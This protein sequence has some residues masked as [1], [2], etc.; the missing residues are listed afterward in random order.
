MRFILLLLL[1]SFFFATS[2]IAKEY[3][4]K[5]S[6]S[7]KKK[8]R[9]SIIISNNHFKKPRVDQSS[10]QN[11]ATLNRYLNQLDPYSKHFS[12]KEVAFKQKRGKT[13]RLGIGLDLLID[14]D[15]ILGVPIKEG[16][17]YQAGIT[18]PVYICSINKKKIKPSEFESYQF[19][20]EFSQ[21]QIVEIQTMSKTAKKLGKYQLKVQ[22]FPQKYVDIKLAG[23]INVLSI[24]QF[25]NDSTLKI[26]NALKSFADNKSLIIDLRFNPGGDLYAT[27]DTLSFFIKQNLTVAYLKENNIKNAIPLKTVSGRSISDKKV[28]LLLSQFTASSAEIFAQAI[29]HYL[30]QT[31]FVGSSTAG[32]CLAQETHLLKHKTAIQLSVYEVLNARKEHCQNKPLIADIKI[33][34]I[35]TMPLTQ[36]INSLSRLK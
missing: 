19:L 28:Y 34:N 5:A 31:V 18:T 25:S 10:L 2:L 7:K 15:L 17:A 8:Q 30:P 36:V 20:T 32:K 33:K 14:G 9:I 16:P 35:E 11:T 21:G 24:R 1:G 23:K 27:I 12:A 26:K 3:E 22:L 29:K 13:K 4:T 6:F